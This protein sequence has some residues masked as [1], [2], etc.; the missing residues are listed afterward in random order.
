M[1]Q[2]AIYA[3]IATVVLYVIIVLALKLTVPY[4]VEVLYALI[5]LVYVFVGDT[6]NLA[7]FK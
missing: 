1:F 3:I 7:R 6:A 5:V 4:W 2:R